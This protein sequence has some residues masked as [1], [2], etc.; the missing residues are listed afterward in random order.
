MLSARSHRN[1]TARTHRSD[2]TDVFNMSLKS[3]SALGVEHNSNS[4]APSDRSA[5]ADEAAEATWE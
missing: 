2:G 5:H 4:R 3:E 1:E